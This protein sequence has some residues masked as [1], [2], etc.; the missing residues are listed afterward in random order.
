MES[1]LSCSL[2]NYVH[3]ARRVIRMP[4]IRKRKSKHSL[5]MSVFGNGNGWYAPAQLYF[6]AKALSNLWLY[7]G[8]EN[9]ENHKHLLLGCYL[10]VFQITGWTYILLKEGRMFLFKAFNWNITLFIC[11]VLLIYLEPVKFCRLFLPRPAECLIRSHV[12]KHYQKF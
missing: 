2:F 6:Q 1:V 12:Q 7:N 11:H 3:A 9:T 10:W 4:V 5:A 8:L